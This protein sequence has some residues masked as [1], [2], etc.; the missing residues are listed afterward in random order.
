MTGRGVLPSPT[1]RQSRKIF[2]HRDTQ[3]AEGRKE[4]EEV[5]GVWKVWEAEP[6]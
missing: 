4:R 5:W 6:S 2:K 3:K 1:P